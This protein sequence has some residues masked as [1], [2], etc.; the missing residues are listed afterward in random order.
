MHPHASSGFPVWQV[1][2]HNDLKDLLNTADLRNFM[3]DMC[4]AHTRYTHTYN[5]HGG[6]ALLHACTACLV[7]SARTIVAAIKIPVRQHRIL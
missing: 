4:V 1:A 2:L 5:T 7:P 3:E 6:G